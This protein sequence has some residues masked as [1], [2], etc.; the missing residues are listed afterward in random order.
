MV[1]TSLTE[2]SEA[3]ADTK[4]QLDGHRKKQQQRLP[5]TIKDQMGHALEAATGCQGLMDL[6]DGGD[7][8]LRSQIPLG[9]RLILILRHPQHSNTCHRRAREGAAEDVA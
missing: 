2:E 7:N 5:V 3:L 8:H 1:Y 4:N 6:T 9:G